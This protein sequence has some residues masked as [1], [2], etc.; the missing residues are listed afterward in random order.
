VVLEL[1]GNAGVIVDR[2]ANLEFAAQR[3]L[4]GAF[5]YAGQVCISVQRA[6]IHEAVFSEFSEHIVAAAGK[7]QLGDPADASTDLGPMIDDRA[8]HRI[9]NWVFSPAASRMAASTS[10]PSSSMRPVN[11]PSALARPLRRS[12]TCSRSAT[13]PTV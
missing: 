6:Y 5:A 8:V 4:T 3:V 11:R 1:G 2:D 9:D 7:M 12:S 13:G 10:R